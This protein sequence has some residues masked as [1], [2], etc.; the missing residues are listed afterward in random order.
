MNQENTE[1]YSLS[2]I[3]LSYF[4]N[5]GSLR[6]TY[7]RLYICDNCRG[8]FVCKFQDYDLCTNCL[9]PIFEEIDSRLKIKMN[10]TNNY[11]I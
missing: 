8:F 1:H 4:D 11:N 3:D 10:L 6:H 2:K 5:F 9:R 7:C